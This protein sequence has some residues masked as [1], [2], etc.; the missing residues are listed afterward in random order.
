[1][2]LQASWQTL[3]AVPVRVPQV[4]LE[5]T[6]DA[7]FSALVTGAGAAET[8]KAA[9]RIRAMMLNCIFNDWN[10]SLLVDG[11]IW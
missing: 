10:K 1:M 9:E 11:K 6:L 7:R 8:T 2:T 4:R 5:S 3:S